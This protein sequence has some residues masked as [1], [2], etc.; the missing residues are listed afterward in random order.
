M[1]ISPK[2]YEQRFRELSKRFKQCAST[3][4]AQIFNEVNLQQSAGELFV[5]AVQRGMLQKLKGASEIV[6]AFS[7]AKDAEDAGQIVG[8]VRGQRVD[9]QE[10]PQCLRPPIPVNLFLDV[11]GEDQVEVFN[12]GGNI[13]PTGGLPPAGLLPSLH[14]SWFPA[15]EFH[16][17]AIVTEGDEHDDFV[18]LARAAAIDR[19]ALACELLADMIGGEMS[20]ATGGQPQGANEAGEDS[21]RAGDSANANDRMKA[22]L[23]ANLSEVKGLTA[24]QWAKRLGYRS[25]ST[26]TDT[27][28]W[29][30]LSMLRADAKAQ[31]ATDRHRRSNTKRR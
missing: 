15:N 18:R 29:K 5:D 14:P 23:A 10:Q 17:L 25:A 31:K 8:F 6:A 11:A 27:P 20:A 1:T 28:T 13:K 22:E 16:Y 2:T 12:D 7:E 24:R 3:H 9:F 4:K 30:E 26:I 21:G 19:Y